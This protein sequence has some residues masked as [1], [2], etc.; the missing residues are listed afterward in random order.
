MVVCA[1]DERDLTLT[2]LVQRRVLRSTYGRIRD[3]SVEE[4][5]GHVVVSGQV[6]SHHLRQ[7]ALHAAL[8]LLAGDRVSSRITVV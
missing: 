2:Q 5:S 1:I 6:N 4:D 7:L 8:E 3:L